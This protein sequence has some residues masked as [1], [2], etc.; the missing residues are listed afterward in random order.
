MQAEEKINTLYE[1]LN[2]V[3]KKKDSLKKTSREYYNV[4]TL[5][6]SYYEKQI[7]TIEQKYQL[8]A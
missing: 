5:L 4:L 1:E 7:Q 3:K 2:L 6:I 8:S